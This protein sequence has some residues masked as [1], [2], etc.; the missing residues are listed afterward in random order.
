MWYFSL[1]FW[2]SRYTTSIKCCAQTLAL[3]VK[4]SRSLNVHGF[5]RIGQTRRCYKV[6][7]CR[8]GS[9]FFPSNFYHAERINCHCSFCGLPD[10]N[11]ELLEQAFAQTQGKFTR[12][13]ALEFSMDK[14]T[15]QKMF[16][17]VINPYPTLDCSNTS[18]ERLYGSFGNVW[19]NSLALTKQPSSLAKIMV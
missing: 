10:D 8:I 16:R 13:A 1:L 12:N 14:I 11:T 6:C 15:I 17:K 18:R 9:F 5:S 3:G 4:V 2:S 19:V 7:S